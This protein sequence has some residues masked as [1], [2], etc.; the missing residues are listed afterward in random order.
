MVIGLLYWN[1]W[2]RPVHF[3]M[4]FPAT[5]TRGL[6]PYENDGHDDE[7]H[8]TAQSRIRHRN[9]GRQHVQRL[10]VSRT[11]RPSHVHKDETVVDCSATTAASYTWQNNYKEAGRDGDIE[12]LMSWAEDTIYM[13]WDGYY[14]ASDFLLGIEQEIAASYVRNASNMLIDQYGIPIPLQRMKTLAAAG[15]LLNEPYSRYDK[16]IPLLC[17]N[18][19]SRAHALERLLRW[20]RPCR[21]GATQD[22]LSLLE[23]WHRA[24]AD[25]SNACEAE[26]ILRNSLQK[27]E[28]GESNAQP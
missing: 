7:G 2:E 11:D 20:Q 13:S 10:C 19:R 21:H 23:Q 12:K 8:A 14:T 27:N 6:L 17:G 28:S 3:A 9:A 16:A 25:R 5:T 18:Y 24:H 15:I 4:R 22:A 26:N 1:Q